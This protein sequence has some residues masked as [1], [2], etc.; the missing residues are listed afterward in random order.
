MAYCTVLESCPGVPLSCV[1][2]FQPPCTR[3]VSPSSPLFVRAVAVAVR[4]KYESE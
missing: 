1:T 4:E 3:D 2:E